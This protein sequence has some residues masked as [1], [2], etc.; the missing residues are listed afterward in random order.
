MN[1]NRRVLESE[2]LDILNDVD[3]LADECKHVGD[4]IKRLRLDVES[5][6][7]VEEEVVNDNDNT[8]REDGRV[9]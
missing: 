3:R 8:R 7:N 9:S 5:I 2:I 6:L 4:K 1:R